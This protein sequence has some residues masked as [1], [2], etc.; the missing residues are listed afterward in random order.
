MRSRGQ[1]TRDVYRNHV[2]VD[3]DYHGGQVGAK[4]GATRWSGPKDLGWDKYGPLDRLN[5]GTS[6][7]TK[8]VLGPILVGGTISDAMREYDA[9]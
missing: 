1:S 9:P 3:K 7:T 8:A 2:G 4:Y 5:D 6:P